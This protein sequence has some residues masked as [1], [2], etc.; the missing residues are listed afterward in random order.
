[1]SWGVRP[2][3]MIGHSIGE[4]VAACLAGVFTLEEALRLVAARGWL[5]QQLP[6]GAML[7][8]R[9]PEKEVQAL[10][11]GDLAL[12]A[13][14]APSLCVVSGTTAAVDALQ[15]QLAE[16]RVASRPVETS[17]AFHSPMMAPI[18]KS[19]MDVVREVKL[20]APEVP[21][22]SN[23]TGTWMTP[24]QATDPAY[25]AKHLR[26]SV[27]FADG[28]GEL[29][30]APGRILLEVGPRQTLSTFARQHS[31]KNAQS[32]VLSSLPQTPR[33]AGELSVLLNALGQ[34]WLA[35]VPVDWRG[36]YVHQ[37]P[38][39]EPRPNH[40][41]P[42]KRFWIEPATTGHPQPAVPAAVEIAERQ[43]VRP[44]TVCAGQ[45]Q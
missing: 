44:D 11:N 14:N 1:M 19:F 32:L 7:A 25:W 2:E 24:E 17:H 20:K 28:I 10:L 29:F 18:L 22:L 26:Q 13:V 38:R 33:D 41:L 27:R 3:S 12:A 4:Y 8:V 42:R 35:G 21:F 36:F 23:V 5:M 30:Q 16:R 31:A 40:P 45:A 37:Q 15:G 6:G 9:L 43:E 34:L 39:R